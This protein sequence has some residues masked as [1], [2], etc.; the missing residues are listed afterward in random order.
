[1]LGRNEKRVA[2]PAAAGGAWT[3]IS[4][5]VLSSQADLDLVLD[6]VTYKSFQV[7]VNDL[8]PETDLTILYLRYSTDGGS[9]FISSGYAWAAHGIV[10]GANTD[11]HQSGSDSQIELTAKSATDL[12]GSDTDESGSYKIMIHNPGTA[13]P[14]ISTFEFGYMAGSAKWCIGQGAGR[15]IT[16]QDTTAIKLIMSGGTMISGTVHLLGL[17]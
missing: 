10:V 17:S 15:H 11:N 16:A 13:E 14:T 8:V 12:L 5:T 1:M 9:S 4:S 2:G 7:L 3:L 6:T